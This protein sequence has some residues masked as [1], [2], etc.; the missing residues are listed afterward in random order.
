MNVKGDEMVHLVMEQG[1]EMVHPSSMEVRW[2]IHDME[3][4]GEVVHP[5]YSKRR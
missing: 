1:G 5:F 3:N 2:S 4:G